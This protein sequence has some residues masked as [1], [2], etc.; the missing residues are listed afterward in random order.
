MIRRPPRS[1]LFPYTTLFRSEA[2][3]GMVWAQYI[4]A[5]AFSS[6]LLGI[7]HSISHAVCAYYDIHHGLNNG[8]GLSRVMTFNQPAATRRYADVAA[9]MGEDTREIGRAHV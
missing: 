3:E 7:M 8:V 6:A 4:A 1:T 5:Q 2:M 9:A